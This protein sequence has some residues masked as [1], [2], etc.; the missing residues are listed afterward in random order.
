MYPEIIFIEYDLKKNL[1]RVQE[2][3]GLKTKV[4]FVE[5]KNQY[6]VP[7]GFEGTIITSN[8]FKPKYD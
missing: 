8:F 1:W 5:N 2:N 3:Y 7:E 4:L 6:K